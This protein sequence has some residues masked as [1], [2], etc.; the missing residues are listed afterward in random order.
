MSTNRP[1]RDFPET[2]G[3]AAGTSLF[4]LVGVATSEVMAGY[5]LAPRRMLRLHRPAGLCPIT[6]LQQV[7]TPIE[8]SQNRRHKAASARPTLSGKLGASPA[9]ANDMR[10]QA[11]PPYA[12]VHR[13]KEVK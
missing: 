4:T 3:V 13:R 8:K 2:A 11:F 5:R 7:Q 1:K 9:A 12:G 10:A 6:M